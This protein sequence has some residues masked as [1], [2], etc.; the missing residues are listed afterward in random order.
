MHHTLFEERCSIFIG[1]NA[2]LQFVGDVILEALGLIPPRINHLA[3]TFLN[4]F[5]SFKTLSAIQKDKFRF[6]HEDC[7][8][9]WILE[10]LLI[11]GDIYYSF[12]DEWGREFIFLRLSFVAFSFFN[13]CFITYII[14]KYKLYH[15]LYQGH[16][17]V[18]NESLVSIEN[19]PKQNATETIDNGEIEMVN[20]EPKEDEPLKVDDPAQDESVE[21]SLSNNALTDANDEVP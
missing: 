12:H 7:Q 3:L 5:I 13:W 21:D 14:I 17:D 4:A 15:I 9:F 6:L 16:V 1:L 19:A 18:E 11:I 2:I 20:A 10:L 8:V